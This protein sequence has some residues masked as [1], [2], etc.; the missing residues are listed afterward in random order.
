MTIDQSDFDEAE[1]A[2]EQMVESFETLTTFFRRVGGITAD[3]A[4]MYPLGHIAMALNNDHEYVG[5][6]P[7]TIFGLLDDIKSD[8]S[9]PDEDEDDD[10][11]EE[12]VPE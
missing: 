10:P 6:D 7:F 4:R 9:E 5:K 8:L 11:E 2:Y 3:R 12:V 1:E